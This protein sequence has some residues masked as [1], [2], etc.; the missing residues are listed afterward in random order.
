MFSLIIHNT[1]QAMK[2]SN[3][4]RRA[5]ARKTR[6]MERAYI[7]SLTPEERAA[8]S[9]EN[10]RLAEEQVERTKLSAQA[11]AIQM[12]ALQKMAARRALEAEAD[13]TYR[14]KASDHY[15]PWLVMEERLGLRQTSSLV[16]AMARWWADTSK[17]ESREGNTQPLEMPQAAAQAE[18][19]VDAGAL[20]RY[21]AHDASP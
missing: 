17:G 2:S 11:L 13:A 18:T 19:A 5:A 14:N 12:E 10:V 4:A 6:D 15:D 7:S 3:E 21:D 1:V 16:D 9:A 8:Y 20:P